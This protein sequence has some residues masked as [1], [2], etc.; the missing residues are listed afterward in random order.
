MRCCIEIKNYHHIEKLIFLHFQ[1]FV[2]QLSELNYFFLTTYPY[3]VNAVAY[4]ATAVNY[5]RIM[6][7]TLAPG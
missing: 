2:A 5:E 1:I 4:I 3:V 6:V 7:K